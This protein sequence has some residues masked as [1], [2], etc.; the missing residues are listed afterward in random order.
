[1]LSSVV[2]EVNQQG[3]QRFWAID[4][5]HFLLRSIDLRGSNWEKTGGFACMV[6]FR[7]GAFAMLWMMAPA[8]A[9]PQKPTDPT[10]EQILEACSMKQA[11]R[12]PSPFIDVRPDHWAF[13]SVLTMHYCGAYRGGIPPQQFQKFL[14][15]KKNKQS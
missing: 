12:L 15:E 6:K 11:E 13:K 8:F 7:W 9:Q 5:F 2:H 10:Q 3:F 1:M 14:E 4:S